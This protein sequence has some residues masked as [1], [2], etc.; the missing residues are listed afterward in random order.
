ML[1]HSVGV[2]AFGII[3]TLLFAVYTDCAEYGA[4]PLVGLSM[5]L[6]RRGFFGPRFDWVDDRVVSCQ[7]VLMYRDGTYHEELQSRDV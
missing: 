6:F 5:W 7:R 4:R 1:M 2:V 3:I